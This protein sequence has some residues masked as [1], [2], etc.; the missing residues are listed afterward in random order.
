MCMHVV[1]V[2]LAGVTSVPLARGFEGVP[3]AS[4]CVRHALDFEVVKY[5]PNC[6]CVINDYSS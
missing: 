2:D 4:L 6:A 5:G 1:C 3:I